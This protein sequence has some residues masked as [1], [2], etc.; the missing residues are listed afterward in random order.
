MKKEETNCIAVIIHPFT[1]SSSCSVYCIYVRV[2]QMSYVDDSCF[3]S[4]D[5]MFSNF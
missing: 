3:K 2:S 4:F 1:L 5:L